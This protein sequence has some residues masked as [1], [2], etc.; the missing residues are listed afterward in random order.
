MGDLTA[1]FSTSEMRCRC[2]CSEVLIHRKLVEGLQTLRKI[3][4]SPIHIKS[5]YRC[6]KHNEKIGGAKK[7]LHLEGKA[8]DIVIEGKTVKDMYSLA[9]LI[10]DFRNGGIGIYDGG[11]IHVDVRDGIAR[12]GR[13][14]S[15]YISIEKALEVL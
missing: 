1:N 3:S 13:V 10:P 15:E 12:W 5:A 4:A 9:F 8:A 7:S 14:N 2:G 6:A 11:F